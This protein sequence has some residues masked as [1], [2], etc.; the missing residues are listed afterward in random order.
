MRPISELASSSRCFPFYVQSGLKD[1]TFMVSFEVRPRPD[2]A[3]LF[4]V[5]FFS[6]SLRWSIGCVVVGTALCLLLQFF[7][8]RRTRSR[9]GNGEPGMFVLFSSAIC[10]T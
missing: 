3:V 5:V 2:V 9:G 1:F 10:C 4:W 7:R 6:F 8:Q